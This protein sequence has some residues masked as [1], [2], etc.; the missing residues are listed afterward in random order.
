[1]FS[2]LVCIKIIQCLMAA[3]CAA[4]LGVIALSIRQR[5][6]QRAEEA[7]RCNKADDKE[8]LDNKMKSFRD[9]FGDKQED[10]GSC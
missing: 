9:H 5:S 1:M 7:D 3:I 6:V 4:L 2:I 8:R 10:D